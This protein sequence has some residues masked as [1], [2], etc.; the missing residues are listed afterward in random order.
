MWTCPHLSSLQLLLLQSVSIHIPAVRELPAEEQAALRA[1]A[2]SWRAAVAAQ[3]AR[4]AMARPPAEVSVVCPPFQAYFRFS[5]PVI[6]L[7]SGCFLVLLAVLVLMEVG[8]AVVTASGDVVGVDGG[9]QSSSNAMVS[10][11][12]LRCVGCSW[13]EVMVAVEEAAVGVY[14]GTAARAW[15]AAVTARHTSRCG[16]SPS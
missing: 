15:R 6:R 7:L 4:H 16:A 10:L 8:E 9:N 12:Q 5:G 2:T 3:G 1:A 13:F 11:R 14:C